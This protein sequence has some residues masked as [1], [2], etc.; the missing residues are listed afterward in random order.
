MSEPLLQR[1]A[2][3]QCTIVSVSA[4]MQAVTLFA[5]MAWSKAFHS[6]FIVSL[7]DVRQELSCTKSC[8]PPAW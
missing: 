7:E 8:R 1:Q 4:L 6:S 2:N 5:A 3:S